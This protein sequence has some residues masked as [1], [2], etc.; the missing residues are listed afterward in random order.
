MTMKTQ[1]KCSLIAAV[2]LGTGGGLLALVNARA[3]TTPAQPFL[4]APATNGAATPPPAPIVTAPAIILPAADN[5]GVLDERRR[6][7]LGMI[8]TGNRDHEI[9]GAGEISRYQIMPSV[10]RQYSDSRSYQNPKISLEVAQ[11]H[12][13]ALYARFKQQAR[14]DPTD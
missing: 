5:P 4:P 14:R 9:G 13:S 11:Q 10:W 1:I 2:L 7:A 6:F 8:E 3:A 12:W